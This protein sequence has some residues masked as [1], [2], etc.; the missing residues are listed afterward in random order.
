MIKSGV[1][2]ADVG[3]VIIHEV[4]LGLIHIHQKGIIHR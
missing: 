3:K 4:L 1:F 2:K